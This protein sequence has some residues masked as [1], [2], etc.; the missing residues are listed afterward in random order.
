MRVR[1]FICPAI[2]RIEVEEFELPPL[3]DQD[4]LIENAYTAVSVGTELYLYLHGSEPIRPA[5]FPHTTGYCSMGV[6]I[7]AGAAVT[8]VRVGDRVAAQGI[9]ASH[10]VRSRAYYRVPDAVPS[11]AAVFLVM[12]AI[13]MHGIRKAR[14]ELGESVAVL[15]LGIVGQLALSLARLCGALPAIA[16]DLDPRRLAIAAGRGADAVLNPNDTPD[17]AGRVRGLCPDDGANVVIE[18]T[19]KPAA[20][21]LA[22]KLACTAGRVV[23]LG[24]PRGTVE[25]SFF[26]DVHLRELDLIGAH[27]P[28]TPEQDHI[29]Y[30][31]NKPRDRGLVLDLMARGRLP[32]TDLITHRAG[33]EDCQ[34]IYDMLADRPQE[35]LGVV[36]QWK[37]L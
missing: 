22:V 8:D 34:A 21:P 12:G 20:Y 14:I 4:I 35:A 10:D 6:V 37:E 19:G 13:A 28:K 18:A 7:D 36:F 29:Y 2:R 26:E 9:H 17:V 23:A 1:R 24:S 15:G 11:E 5:Q 3:G 25:M 31:W 32:V 27:Q 33:S 16:I 30:R